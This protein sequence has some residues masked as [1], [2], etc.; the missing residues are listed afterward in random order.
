M[1][2]LTHLR[3]LLRLPSEDVF[4]ESLNGYVLAM[5]DR[6]SSEDVTVRA[7]SCW[8]LAFL[9]DAPTQIEVRVGSELAQQSVS[10]FELP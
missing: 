6:Q 9:K 2:T 4:P 3:E 8:A 10:A 5:R 1:R 7:L